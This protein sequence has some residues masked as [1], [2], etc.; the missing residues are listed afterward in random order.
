M[1]FYFTYDIE[2]FDFTRLE[3]GGDIY[4]RTGSYKILCASVKD[5]TQ[6]LILFDG[7][8]TKQVVSYCL[9]WEWP[10]SGGYV[11]LYDGENFRQI[12][13]ANLNNTVEEGDLVFGFV[14]AGSGYFRT[15]VVL[16][17]VDLD[18]LPKEFLPLN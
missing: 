8:P 17:N 5:N 3:E 13:L 1:E 11:T 18:K 6:G 10:T 4:G 16:R 9:D 7:D 15:M 2:N 12:Q 14:G